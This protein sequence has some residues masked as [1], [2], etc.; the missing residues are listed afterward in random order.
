MFAT[1]VL[2]LP[3]APPSDVGQLLATVEALRAKGI[4]PVVMPSSP[5]MH[6]AGLANSLPFQM[7]GGRCV[8]LPNRTFDPME[9]WRTVARER[10]MCMIIV[11]DAFARP[12]LDALEE[13]K[14]RGETLDLTSL[15]IVISS[16]VIWS[17][18]VKEKMLEWLDATLID[19]V[20]ATE[21]PMALQVS[22]R[23][24]TGASAQFI[25]LAETRLFAEDGREIPK[26]SDEHGTDCRGRPG[27]A[28]RLLQGSGEDGQDLPRRRR[29]ALR[30]HRRLGT[31]ERGRH[32][33]AARARLGLHQHRR[34]KGLPG[35]SRARARRRTPASPTAS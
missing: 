3:A 33:A 18:G 34:R 10:V 32:A 8:T 13:A 25:P 20:G 7:L 31:V 27:I 28:R 19:G 15:K 24:Q 2:G 29:P 12:M 35:G 14:S 23:G 22:R 9:I 21:G 11:G 1:N 5:L 4:V 16:G 26:G 30:V 6:T 17:Q